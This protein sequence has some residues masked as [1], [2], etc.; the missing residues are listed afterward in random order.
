MP[1]VIIW[2]VRRTEIM[3]VRFAAENQGQVAKVSKMPKKQSGKKKKD[4]EKTGKGIK[5]R[6]AHEG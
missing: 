5:R 2:E 4:K 6:F 1:S 3:I